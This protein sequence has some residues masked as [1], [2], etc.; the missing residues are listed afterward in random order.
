MPT[1]PQARQHSDSYPFCLS[2]LTDELFLLNSLTAD[3]PPTPPNR[4]AILTENIVEEVAVV[5]VGLKALLQG[6]TT[7][8]KTKNHTL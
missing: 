5:V 6:G 8:W 7:L 4:K 1:L 2:I 3:S